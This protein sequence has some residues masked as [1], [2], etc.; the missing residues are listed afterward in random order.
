M[1]EREDLF[2]PSVLFVNPWRIWY[3]KREKNNPN[4][5]EHEIQFLKKTFT[6]NLFDVYITIGELN[7]CNLK[8]ISNV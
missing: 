8:K 1:C 6:S 5:K 2:V 4:V 7:L 3:P